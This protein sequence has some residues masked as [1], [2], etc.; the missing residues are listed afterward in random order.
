MTQYLP[1]LIKEIP[2]EYK[3]DKQEIT[4]KISHF[5]YHTKPE[6][7]D[8]LRQ[9]RSLYPHPTFTKEWQ[10][11]YNLHY[12]INNLLTLESLAENRVHIEDTIFPLPTGEQFKVQKGTKLMKVLKKFAEVVGF[13]LFENFRNEHSR[14]LQAKNLKGTLCISIHPLDFMTMSDNANNWSSCMSWMDAGEYRLGTVEMMNSPYVLMAYLKSDDKQLTWGDGNSWN[15]KTW[16]CLYIMDK[17]KFCVSVKS[18]PFY[19]KGLTQIALNAILET[20]NWGPSEITTFNPSTSTLQFNTNAMYNDFGSTEHWI[21]TKVPYPENNYYFN[22]SGE[23]NCMYCGQEIDLWNED[24]R[25]SDRLTCDE[26]LCYCD[27][28]GD[29]IYSRDEYSYIDGETV[30]EHCLNEEAFYD[31]ILETYCWN[32]DAFELYLACENDPVST[33]IQDPSNYSPSLWRQYFTTAV[34]YD[35]ETNRYYVHVNECT[36]NALRYLYHYQKG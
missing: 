11:D 5:L 20:F 3:E 19:N 6:Y 21:A 28:C 18:Y 4:N 22:Y 23:A 15:S 2:I 7:A 9:V 24:E 27:C 16:R 31:N 25:E 33:T 17:D 34:H 10:S 13:S 32:R 29:R 35:E 36:P 14:C 26:N 30:C 1:D 12:A 8:F